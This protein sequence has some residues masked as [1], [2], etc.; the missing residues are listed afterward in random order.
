MDGSLRDPQTEV[1]HMQFIRIH[2][3]ASAVVAI[4]LA[5]TAVS[6]SAASARAFE[7]A[8]HQTVQPSLAVPP[9]PTTAQPSEPRAVDAQAALAHSYR[10]PTTARYNN[11][12]LNARHKAAPTAVIPAPK[13]AAPSGGFHW[14]DAAIGAAIAMAIVLLVTAG[15]V[16]VRRRTQF[17]EA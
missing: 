3:R 13:A 10:V 4:A 8:H 9:S 14:A 2:R 5:A 7:G 1:S 6:A 16:M 11:A 17:G 15:T 12:E